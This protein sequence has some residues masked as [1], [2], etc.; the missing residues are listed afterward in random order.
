[1][2]AAAEGDGEDGL[3]EVALAGVHFLEREALADGRHEDPVGALGVVEAE[4]RLGLLVRVE[5]AEEGGGRGG[6]LFAGG[7]AEGG[8]GGGHQAERA[9]EAGE[10]THGG[11]R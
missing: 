2:A 3:G 1:V 11:V 5:R 6:Q 9:Q 10:G 8:D 7:M 4:G